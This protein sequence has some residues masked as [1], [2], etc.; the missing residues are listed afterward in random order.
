MQPAILKLSAKSLK[1]LPAYII[2]SFQRFRIDYP[3]DEPYKRCL[4]CF[5]ETQIN[6]LRST[7]NYP[8]ITLNISMYDNKQQ[9]SL[10]CSYFLLESIIRML[11]LCSNLKP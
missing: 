7:K 11:T 8:D 10:E 2:S 5:N 1:I 9:I 3:W 4:S 6:F